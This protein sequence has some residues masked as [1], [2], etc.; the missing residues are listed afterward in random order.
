MKRV[1]RASAQNNN[2]ISQAEKLLSAA[3]QMLDLM[4]SIDEDVLEEAE[5]MGVYNELI[6]VI[7]ALQMSLSGRTFRPGEKGLLRISDEVRNRINFYLQ[8]AEDEQEEFQ[9]FDSL[10]EVVDRVANSLA[11]SEPYYVEGEEFNRDNIYKLAENFR[12]E[13]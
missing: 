1:I 11:D 6:D 10:D 5:M 4:D 12:W 7:P 3:K 13:F 9:E 8:M 2:K